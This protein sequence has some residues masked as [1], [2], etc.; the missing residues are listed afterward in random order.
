[1]AKKK[2]AKSKRATR[3]TSAYLSKQTLLR[4][5]SKSSRSLSS[6]AMKQ[7]GFV[8]TVE[9]GWVVK[10]D[11]EGNTQQLQKLNE[12]KGTQFQLD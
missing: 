12:E 10:K 7:R 11:K 4:A 8:V 5:I 1:M 6:S 2:E 3:K 9:N